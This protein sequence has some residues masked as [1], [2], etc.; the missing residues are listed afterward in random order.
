MKLSL[1]ESIQE[2]L[3]KDSGMTDRELTDVLHGI[4]APQQPVNQTC[5]TLEKKGIV[6]RRK[7]HDGLVGNYLTGVTSADT[8]HPHVVET[9]NQTEESLSEDA[10]KLFLQRWLTQQ[11]WQVDIAWGRTHG[12]D[13]KAKK[14]NQ[15]WL[16]E[17]KGSGSLQPMRV[18]YFLGALGEI[19]Q[20]MDDPDAK[21]SLAFPDLAQFRSLWKKLPALAKARLGLTVLF[22]DQQGNITHLD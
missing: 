1:S 9:S 11:G 12:T 22:V 20:Q 14:G 21:Y 2:A 19:L 16:M 4:G 7:R 5:R 10:V 3:K 17:V 13:V 18:N 15:R 6:I 8:N